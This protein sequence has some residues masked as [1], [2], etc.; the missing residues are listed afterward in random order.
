[1]AKNTGANFHDLRHDAHQEL[2]TDRVN[3]ALNPNAQFYNTSRSDHDMESMQSL[4]PSDETEI[5]DDMST[6]AIPRSETTYLPSLSRSQAMS[7][8]VANQ[9]SA[10]ADHTGEI[11]RQRLIAENELRQQDI[12]QTRQLELVRQRLHLCYSQQLRH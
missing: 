2:R 7:D 9:S 11:E 6:R 3:R 12:I 8:D 5:R 10:V 4:P 1:M